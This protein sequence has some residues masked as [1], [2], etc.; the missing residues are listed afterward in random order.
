MLCVRAKKRGSGENRRNPANPR[1][2]DPL[3]CREG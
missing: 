2:G 1:I 3:H